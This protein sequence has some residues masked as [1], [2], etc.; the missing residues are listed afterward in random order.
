MRRLLV[1]TRGDCALVFRFG[2]LPGSKDRV[3]LHMLRVFYR[4]SDRSRIHQYLPCHR[5]ADSRRIW[6]RGSPVGLCDPFRG[7][8]VTPTS[9]G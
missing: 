4:L 6:F 3:D 9:K 1:L 2:H 5:R 8:T 7:E